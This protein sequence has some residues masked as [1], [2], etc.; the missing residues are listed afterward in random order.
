MGPLPQTTVDTPQASQDPLQTNSASS[1][2]TTKRKRDSLAPSD[3][4]PPSAKHSKSSHRHAKHWDL[5]GDLF[6]RIND[7]WMRLRKSSL[8]KYSEWFSDVFAA[9][10]EGR[11]MPDPKRPYVEGTIILVDVKNVQRCF[12]V[13]ALSV[14][15][16]DF[17]LILNAIDN[18]ISFCH[19]PPP[20][21][22]IASIL[23][24]ATEL[25]FPLFRD[26][27]TQSIQQMWCP[28]LSPLS[29]AVIP[30]ATETV[31]LGRVWGVSGVLKRSLYELLRT[32]G[33]GQDPEELDFERRPVLCD[34]RLL[35]ADILCLVHAREHLDIIWHAAT[36]FDAF[37]ISHE[38]GSSSPTNA[39]A[40]SCSP[41]KYATYKNL[42]HDTGLFQNY[43]FDVLCGLEMLMQIDWESETA[44]AE[45]RGLCAL[46]ASKIRER[47]ETERERTWERLDVVLRLRKAGT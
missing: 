18:A 24:V 10:D 47:W 11:L 41:I 1:E 13:Q 21:P 30:H 29:T 36:S 23:R 27:A 16:V 44:D 32:P 25:K 43:R 37:S 40:P 8:A 31:V 45:G 5:E 12:H 17:D 19:N 28:S 2:P 4:E 7:C 38:H 39:S 33:F 42:V 35:P 14:S 34:R 20:F 3:A 9:I 6:V 15:V 22:V 26:W 46:C